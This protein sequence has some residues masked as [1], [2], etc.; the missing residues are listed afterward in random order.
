[1]TISI[2]DSNRRFNAEL[3]QQ[4]TG[5]LP[6]GHVYQLGRPGVILLSTGIPD[7]PSDSNQKFAKEMESIFR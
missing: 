4:I 3:Q 1:M 5:T 7:F 2:E 6:K